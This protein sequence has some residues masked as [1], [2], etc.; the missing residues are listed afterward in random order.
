MREFKN[1]KERNLCENDYIWNSATCSCEKS[2][3][4]GSVIADS[5]IMRDKSIKKLSGAVITKL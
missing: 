5:V 2:K 4:L 3:Y 1:S